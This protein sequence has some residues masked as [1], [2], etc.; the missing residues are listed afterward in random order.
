MKTMK[1]Q[2]ISV[3]TSTSGCLCYHY[4]IKCSRFG[5]LLQGIE[6]ELLNG[7]LRVHIYGA[8]DLLTVTDNG[9]AVM[10]IIDEG[11]C[12]NT[13]TSYASVELQSVVVA[14]TQVVNDSLTPTWNRSFDLLVGHRARYLSILVT[15][16]CGG[17]VGEH[18]GIVWISMASVRHETEVEKWYPLCYNG[19][20]TD[21]EVQVRLKFTSNVQ[22]RNGTDWVP[23]SSTFPL[24]KGNRVTLFQDA[25]VPNTFTPYVVLANNET[26]VQH[27]LWEE[28]YT[29]IANAKHFIYVAG[30]DLLH[31]T[32][33]VRDESR[34]IAGAEG[35]SIG[36][37]LVR[38]SK[39]G[40]KVLVLLWN[41][42]FN[43]KNSA[44][45]S[46]WVEIVKIDTHS[47]EACGYLCESGVQCAL[48]DRRQDVNILD[49]IKLVNEESRSQAI[50]DQY[51][52]WA[53]SH[54]QKL[55]LVDAPV[56]MASGSA[57]L[58]RIEAY[59]GGV[60]LTHGRPAAWDILT[61]FEQ[62]W[63]ILKSKD[64]CNP[65]WLQRFFHPNDAVKELFDFS[66]HPEFNRSGEFFAVPETDPEAWD[67]QFVRSID[68]ASVAG[69]RPAMQL[70]IPQIAGYETSVYHAYVGAIRQA[71][72]FLY[73]ESQYFIGSAP[74]EEGKDVPVPLEI[75][76]KIARKIQAGQQ[77]AV[78]VLIP[79][80][81][82]GVPT[83]AI[84]QEMLHW[85]YDTMKTMYNIVS[86]AVLAKGLQQKPTDYLN[87]FTI[88]NRETEVD[89]EYQPLESMRDSD[90]HYRKAQLYRR[91]PIYV[92]S[93]MMIA[94]DEF[95][96]VGSANI[97]N[98]SMDGRLDT[99]SAI[100]AYQPYHTNAFRRAQPRGQVHGFRMSL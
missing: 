47:H 41:N 39:E 72:A 35:V 98:R 85:Q 19:Q 71:E 74:W 46:A 24:R 60:D 26:F 6:G 79:M 89:G 22:Q 67:V 48:S 94:D 16:S 36:D 29:S 50:L 100:R 58:R 49:W 81:P 31:T 37:L 91:F 93:K 18:V 84:V 88:V 75:A 86:N 70:G 7:T 95:I 34:M 65:S 64:V 33:L 51:V 59:V 99:E 78:Y 90:E 40:V 96:I 54:H 68:N 8:K 28:M 56:N 13:R 61:N 9:T 32:V 1:T 97:N 83:S 62:R 17:G 57:N 44:A 76:L 77:F 66:V 43:S 5:V 55:V 38:K 30:W 3:T 10:G 80:W 45:D 52:A 82:E 73:I 2:Q 14:R 21:A 12:N 25:H 15:A 11:R 87:F 42:R 92:H 63:R 23:L 69:L 53:F 4:L 27:R 20:F